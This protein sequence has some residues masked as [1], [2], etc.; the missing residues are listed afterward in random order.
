[1][2]SKKRFVL[3][4]GAESLEIAHAWPYYLV[5][6]TGF[7]EAEYENVTSA[8]YRRH[9]VTVSGSKQGARYPTITC[10]I[11]EKYTELAERLYRLLPDGEDVE[12]IAYD[13]QGIA[14]CITAR[15]Q[16]IIIPPDGK[17]REVVLTFV[18][19]NP[20]FRDVNPSRYDMATWAGGAEFDAELSDAME[21]EIRQMEQIRT[22]TNP[23]NVIA[24]L[25]VTFR[26]NG[27]VKNPR[28]EDIT[29]GEWMQIDTAMEVG[30][31]IIIRTA[32]GERAKITM[33]GQP[34]NDLWHYGGNWLEL[35]I[36]ETV[37][38]YDTEEGLENLDV[39]IETYTYYRGA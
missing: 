12:I 27:P 37:F 26:A 24:P 28:L 1:M 16:S 9:G 4:R 36:G 21:F 8:S 13:E 38:R 20:F 11:K 23:S 33:N 22:I 3:R 6:S 15:A 39:E 10:T 14:K 2:P 30:N 18:C 19:E 25:T 32:M 35:P 29:T 17:L 34:A 5:T 7:R 31:E